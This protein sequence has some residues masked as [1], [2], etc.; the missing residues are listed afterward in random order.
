MGIRNT[1]SLAIGVPQHRPIGMQPVGNQFGFT[2]QMLV[3]TYDSADYMSRTAFGLGTGIVPVRYVDANEFGGDYTLYFQVE[4]M[5]TMLPCADNLIG[6]TVIGTASLETT[7]G[8]APGPFPAD[9][10]LTVNFTNC[11]GTIRITNFTSIT[12][13]PFPIALPTGTVQ[14]RTTVTQTGGG[15]GTFDAISGRITIPITLHFRH[16]AEAT[17]GALASPSDLNLV[18]T[19]EATGGQRLSNGRFI[20]VASG[21]FERGFLGNSNGSLTVTGGFSPRP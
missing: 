21:R 18:L 3:L 2:P 10:N 6:S 4:R 15:T 12:T 5:D 16:S 20:L 8:R 1:M 7:N 14:N 19:T 13:E 11:R 17:L 9:I